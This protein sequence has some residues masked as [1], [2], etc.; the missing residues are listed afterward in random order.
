MI[1]G[2]YC[3]GMMLWLKVNQDMAQAM[4]AD[5]LATEKIVRL[6]MRGWKVYSDSEVVTVYIKW[7]NIEIAEGQTTIF[8][9]DKVTIK[10]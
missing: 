5:R 7:D 10:Q 1:T 3:M 9:G 2:A 4:M 8:S 6:F